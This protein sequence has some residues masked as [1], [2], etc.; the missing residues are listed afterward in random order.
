MQT[1]HSTL[2][3]YNLQGAISPC[4]AFSSFPTYATLLSRTLVTIT[5][6]PLSYNT[7]F[8]VVL[9]SLFYPPPPFIYMRSVT[10]SLTL[11]VLSFCDLQY[12]PST[13]VIILAS[14]PVSVCPRT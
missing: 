9:C 1:C 10:S 14:T 8:C 11:H 13:V 12:R 3:I 7:V 4:A 2:Y 6:V 5:S